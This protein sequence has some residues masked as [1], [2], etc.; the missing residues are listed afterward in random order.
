MLNKAAIKKIVELKEK[1]SNNSKNR[2]DH[3]P[4]EVSI[5]SAAYLRHEEKNKYRTH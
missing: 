2:S 4:A 3:S 1:K 5:L